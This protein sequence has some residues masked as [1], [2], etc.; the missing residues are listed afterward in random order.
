[1]TGPWQGMRWL[2]PSL[3][4]RI[5][6]LLML[7]AGLSMG[8]VALDP[9]ARQLLATPPL[10]ENEVAFE[11][12]REWAPVWID[13]RSRVAYEKKHLPGARL[14]TVDEKEDFEQ[15]L[16]DIDAQGA[17]DGTRPVVV[18]CGSGSCSLGREVAGRLRTRY[19]H[20]KVFTLAGG[21]GGVF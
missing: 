12:A 16:F 9:E 10:A 8:R 15:L 20:L 1:M 4:Y 18:Y 5:G 6:V 11:I 14:L 21:A 17:L 7:V 19:P 2:T 3:F 13:A